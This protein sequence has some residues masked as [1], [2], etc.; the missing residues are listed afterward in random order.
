MFCSQVPRKA[1]VTCEEVF[2]GVKM[3][4]PVSL[5]TQSGLPDF[6]LVPK[7]LENLFKET[8]SVAEIREKNV[9]PRYTEFPPML[10]YMKIKQGENDPKLEVKVREASFSP[11]RLAKEDEKPTR[12][13]QYGFGKPKFQKFVEGVNY[14]I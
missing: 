1:R 12:Q 8:T 11:Y 13:W 10:K 5:F 7:H 4:E 2:R 14:N 3:T 9:L 6:R